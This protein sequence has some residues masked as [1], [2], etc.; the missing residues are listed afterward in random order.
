VERAIR[1]RVIIFIVL[2]AIGKLGENFSQGFRLSSV[3]VL[4]VSDEPVKGI[5]AQIGFGPV[6]VIL[7]HD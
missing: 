5:S 7:V 4:F 3:A 2:N 1:E 6:V